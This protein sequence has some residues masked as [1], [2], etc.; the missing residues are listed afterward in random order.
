[1]L[2][3]GLIGFRVNS[4][5][6]LTHTA[7]KA[8]HTGVGSEIV[9]LIQKTPDAELRDI[10][11]KIVMVEGGHSSPTPEQLAHTAPWHGP[12]PVHDKSTPWYW[13]LQKTNGSLAAY[14]DGLLYMMDHVR[15]I[16]RSQICH[17]AYIVNVDTA[18]LEIYLGQQFEYGIGRYNSIPTEKGSSSENEQVGCKLAM[19]LD[20]ERLRSLTPV[21]AYQL[22]SN[23]H[24]ASYWGDSNSC[25]A[26]LTRSK[27]FS[28]LRTPE[29]TPE[30]SLEERLADA[31]NLISYLTHEAKNGRLGLTSHQRRQIQ[32][33]NSK[34]V[35]ADETD[36]DYYGTN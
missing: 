11:Q 7:S 20:F 12:M 23:I 32:A 36:L 28:L 30:P 22:M 2:T 1:M 16:Y 4:V 24:D 6:K 27:I 8:F 17:A 10:A 15:I 25:E 19:E 35:T 34:H 26:M 3:P 33:Y 9:A 21:D 31:Q 18:K 5:D 29:V 13:A 14:K